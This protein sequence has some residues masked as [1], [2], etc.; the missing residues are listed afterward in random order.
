MKFAGLC[1]A[2]QFCDGE[3]PA[4]GGLLVVEWL[5]VAG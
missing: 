4:G 3:A 5:P 2:R 1:R